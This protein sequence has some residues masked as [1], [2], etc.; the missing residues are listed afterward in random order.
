V[1]GHLVGLLTTL[2]GLPLA[3]NKDLQEDKEA[4]FDVIDTLKIELPIAT[5]IICTMKI[6]A[7]RMAAMLNEEMLATDLADYL[8]REGVPF[9]KSHHLVGQ[10]VLRAEELGVPLNELDLSEYQAIH[11]SF[12]ES[13][14]GVFDVQQSVSARAVEGGTAPQAVRNQIKTAKDIIKHL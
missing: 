7:K 14:Y 9:R 3:Y 6:N 11:S 2:K 13:V 12:T 5:G 10:A 8:V 4:L 1:V